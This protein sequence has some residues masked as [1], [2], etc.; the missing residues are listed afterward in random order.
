MSEESASLNVHE[1]MERVKDRAS[2]LTFV[3]ALVEERQKA[4]A[5]ERVESDA[6]RYGAALDWQNSRISD[7][8]DAAVSFMRESEGNIDAPSWQKFALFLY[9]GK[10]YE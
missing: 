3:E 9:M 2:F 1:T 8:L 5:L 10:I 7:Y 6:A 4:E